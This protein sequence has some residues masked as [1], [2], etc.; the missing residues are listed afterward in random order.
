MRT[1]E[2]V[3]LV[4]LLAYLLLPPRLRRWAALAA[5]VVALLH[6]GL[7]GER[8]QMVP[9]YALTAFFAA[10]SLLQLRPAAPLSRPPGPTLRRPKGALARTIA[11]LLIL[12]VALPPSLFPVPR[13]P[14][15]GGPHAVGTITFQWTD[16][17]RPE[18]YTPDPGDQRTIMVQLWYPAIAPA[19]SEPVP[20]MDR[21]D[22]VGPA[23]ATYLRLP[24][25]FLDHAERVRT[26]SY[27]AAPPAP[28]GPF[29][30]VIYSHGWNGF[31]TINL[32]QSEALASHGYIA[33]AVDHTY[34]AM[35]TVFADGS[36]ALND[37]AILPD[38]DESG[39]GAA[40]TALEATYAADLRFTLDQLAALARAD[41]HPL[42]GRLDLDRVGFY[43]HSTGG[44]AVVIAC[45]QDPRCDA[46]LGQ[47]AWLEP[48]PGDLIAAGV[49]QPFLFFRTEEWASGPNDARLD[50]LRAAS[51][52]ETY[53]LTLLGTRHYDFTMLPLLSPLAPVLGLK[54]PLNGQ[55]VLQIN[56]DYLIGF[57]DQYLKNQPSA[58]LTGPRDDDP[59]VRWDE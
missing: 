43:G 48:V 39:F 34:G 55:R 23:I 35:V 29:P 11:A 18:A 59:E 26:H 45:A 27:P 8:W 38:S 12:L 46:G 53:R 14:P 3:L 7:E 4:A 28:G 5:V 37:P 52:A 51:S 15:P 24:S 19:D 54:G 44:G 47:D 25:F 17:A 32:N 16:P 36:V 21:L 13:L 6:L 58:L 10:L 22:V 1:L 30:V 2:I 41:P 56:T 20:W 40:S 57:F 33:V 49:S 31:R 42:A 50:Q 9:A